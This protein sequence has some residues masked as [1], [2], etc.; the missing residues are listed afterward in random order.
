[1]ES[2]P[3]ARLRV[4]VLGGSAGSIEAFATVLSAL[5]AQP[6][7]AVLVISHLDASQQTRLDEVLQHHTAMPVERL[8]QLHKIEHDR[9]YVLPENAGVIALDGHLRLTR[10]PP[11][12]HLPID[13]CL[14]SIAQDPELDGAAVI[15][16]GTG[17][18]G[19]AGIVDVKA[20]GGFVL[21]QSP[22]T[23]L[24]DGMPTAAINTGLVDA[25]L[26]P[27][28]IAGELLQRFGHDVEETRG[29]E[30]QNESL[31]AA[32]V[33]VQQKTGTNLGYIKEAN[34]KRRFLRR[35]LLQ[36]DRDL[37]AYLQLLRSDAREAAALRDDILIGV[38]AF[39]RD[40]EF[41]NVL[42]QTVLPRLVEQA[43]EGIRI[44]VPACSTGE[45]VYTIAMLL[46]EALDAAGLQ[47]RVQIFGTDVNETSIQTARAGRYSA[48]AVENVPE[49]YRSS[50]F[51]AT[52]SGYLVNKDIREMCV[53]ACHNLLTHAP[54]S[55][56]GLISCRNL[57]IYLHKEAQQHVFEVLHY[58]CRPDGFLLLGRAEAATASG[59]FEHA[60][61]PHLYRKLPHAKRARLPALDALQPW[62]GETIK[63]RSREAGDPL[64]EAADRCA[65]ERYAP[66]G[67]V[68]N[69]AG[70]VVQFRGD[71]ARFVAPAD[72]EATLSLPRLLRAE[73]NVPVR[74]ALMEARQAGRP[75]VRERLQ[76][77]GER[78]VLEVLP[79]DQAGDWRHFLV[80]L[81]LQP[82]PEPMQTLALP[83][84]VGGRVD[85]LERTVATLSDELATAQAQLKAM[86]VDFEAANEEL[87]TSNEEMLSANEELQ[88]ANEELHSAKQELESANQELNS[89]NDELRARNEQLALANDDLTN[90]VD[91]IPLPVVLLD[92]QL[93]V[94]HFSPQAGTLFGFGAECIGQPMASRQQRFSPALIEQLVQSAVLGLS[95]L[96]Q[97]QVDAEGRWWLVHVRAYRTADD[98]ID[99]AVIAFQDI[100]ELRQA[101][102][103]AQVARQDAERANAAKDDFLGL[104]S[105]ELR[106]PLH[107]IA[108][109]AAV[110]SKALVTPGSTASDH[111]TKAVETIARHCQLQAQLI[112][113]LLD[114][115]RISS[116]RLTLEMRPVDLCACVRSV[117]EGLQP[118]ARAQSLTLV[119]T[120]LQGSAMVQGD[121][122][123]LQQIASN[124]IGNAIKFTPKGGRV[125]VIVSQ[126]SG[127]V[128]LAVGDDGIG[129]APAL[130]PQLFERFKQSNASRTRQYGGLGLG[131]SIVKHLVQA[132]GGS[133]AA[134]SEGEGRGA[135][136]M[137]RLPLL[138]EPAREPLPLTMPAQ[139]LA[140]L[141][142][143][144][145][146]LV[147]D[148]A[149]AREALAAVIEL[150]GAQVTTASGA[151]QALE[152][153]RD[154]GF[155]ALVSDIAMP[156][157]DG[158][159]LTRQFREHERSQSGLRLYAIALTGLASLED[160]DA[161]LQAGFDDHIA[162]PVVPALLLEKLAL[163]RGRR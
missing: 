52:S 33:Q 100:H 102:Q 157:V 76:L 101:V 45:E 35:V 151:L 9:V 46:R 90:L 40:A 106:A 117:V 5:P 63:L 32:L 66:P 81:Q 128:E 29:D 24:H 58:A 80:T 136:F 99:G 93:R 61:A 160:R 57:L 126:V 10:R 49:P 152:L 6:G 74:T 153:L 114:V 15:L 62:G 154:G 56:M 111:V 121:L 103:N 27:E 41:V 132:H 37:G 98:R 124:L 159:R 77:D 19:A 144:A 134:T 13:A 162:K 71:V 38:T 129:I 155:T 34:L 21:A 120:G 67:F 7:F 142:G 42:R 16:S 18:D 94:R 47:P 140:P 50:A 48:M 11:G 133:V 88:S 30:E 25:V 14:V 86:V 147:D 110:L 84:I 87:R 143:L 60:G 113:D 146:L 115:T 119:G 104:V 108:G 53:F 138:P 127:A 23:A 139:V 83:L 8:T 163:A 75:V 2:L 12:L 161:A 123:R 70:D 36:K 65:L 105:H 79:I 44:W 22:A 97:E 26:A 141:D 145:V 148:D 69:E 78:Y 72:G 149:E 20:G 39:F 131:L 89:L 96:E 1:M 92:R 91:G 68:V 31:R 28:D 156:G 82:V 64:Q 3:N 85:D 51:M 95:A 118:L 158:Y 125:E 59:G 43:H 137:V 112:D 130:L 150:A 17:Q 122:R 73:L 107:V 54:F 109:W 135:R 55:G 4:V 116:G